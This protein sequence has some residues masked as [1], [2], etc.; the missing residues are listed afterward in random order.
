MPAAN[1]KS[2]YRWMRILHRDI[3]F[4]VIG[5]TVIYCLSGIVLTYRDTGFL[6]NEVQIEQTLKPGLSENQ[7]L[8]ALKLKKVK[9]IETGEGQIRFTGGAYNL[10]SGI[11]AY[12]KEEL[13]HALNAFNQ[14]HKAPSNDSRHWFTILYAVSLLFLAL[15]SLWMYRPR[16]TYFKRGVV[17]TIAGSV[18]S[19]LLIIV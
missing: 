14:L 6:K 11:A 8:E 16:T 15:S 9:I 5:L 1:N 19:I 3:G 4:F 17:I 13:P 2:I 18:A 7:L 12:T 10:E